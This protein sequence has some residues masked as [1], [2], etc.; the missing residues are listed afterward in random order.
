MQTDK[1]ERTIVDRVNYLEEKY[2]RL[3]AFTFEKNPPIIH[4]ACLLD[5]EPSFVSMTH[6]L[7]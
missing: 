1:E 3:L 5:A 2:L 6:L 7:I 4:R